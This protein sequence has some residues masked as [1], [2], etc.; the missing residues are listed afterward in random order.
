MNVF[1]AVDATE[2]WLQPSIAH[3]MLLGMTGKHP[4]REQVRRL[5]IDLSSSDGRGRWSF[6]RR[7]SR[8]REARELRLMAG[9]RLIDVTQYASKLKM[10]GIP[11]VVHALITSDAAR[12]HQLVVWDRGALAP[13]AMDASGGITFPA[14]YWRKRPKLPLSQRVYMWLRSSAVGASVLVS[15]ELMGATRILARL[16][17]S[18]QRDGRRRTRARVNIMLEGASMLLPEVPDRATSEALLAFIEHGG[19]MTLQ[20]FVHDLLP[21]THPDLFDDE[22]ILSHVNLLQILR[23]SSRI[24]V[25][26]PLLKEQVEQTLVSLF[27]TTPTTD[28]AELPV[29]PRTPRRD[30][31]RQRRPG[32]DRLLFIGGFDHRKG[33]SALLDVMEHVDHGS[34]KVV[35]VGDPNPLRPTQVALSR[36]AFLTR[37][38]EPR[39]HVPDDE[40]Q[41]LLADADALLYLSHAEGYGLPVLEALSVGTP[42]ICVDTPINRYFATRYGGVT[43]VPMGRASVDSAALLRVL[44]AGVWRQV[45]TSD[46]RSSEMPTDI[47]RWAGIVLREWATS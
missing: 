41:R 19:A 30:R 47:E 45:T 11:R 37:G 17:M 44:D 10:S 35:V 36:R 7:S 29:P 32:P 3:R 4:T 6:L 20:V 34:M 43:L 28:V 18:F 31:G 46:L 12:D 8:R 33:L 2:R 26:S 22:A 25:S 14:R 9:T 38:I 15:L 23:A 1:E 13:V 27:G 42:V 16:V 40:L 24:V 21:L 5:V 39:G